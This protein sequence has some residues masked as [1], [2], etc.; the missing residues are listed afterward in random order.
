MVEEDV[1]DALLLLDFKCDVLFLAVRD[2]MTFQSVDRG[3][4]DNPKLVVVS[5]GVSVAIP[6]RSSLKGEL[7]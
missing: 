4:G 7:D 2:E 1:E 5:H 3:F 6:V